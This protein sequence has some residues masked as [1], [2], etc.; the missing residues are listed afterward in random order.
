MRLTDLLGLLDE[1]LEAFVL[2]ANDAAVLELLL[3]RL[4]ERPQLDRQLEAP[5]VID[6]H[7]LRRGK[8]AHLHTLALRVNRRKV[9]RTLTM[10]S[11]MK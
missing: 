7:L 10:S 8:Q 4:V 5:D 6:P 1:R 3:R 2:L 11:S 9:H